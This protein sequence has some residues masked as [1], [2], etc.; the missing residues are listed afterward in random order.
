MSAS[1][2]PVSLVVAIA[3]TCALLMIV[4][5]FGAWITLS[6]PVGT[7][8]ASGTTSG[9]NGIWTAI[10]GVLA[11]GLLGARV[12]GVTW[13][14]AKLPLEWGVLACFVVAG[15]LGFATWTDLT[16]VANARGWSDARTVGRL[17]GVN[18][19][20]APG[21]GLLVVILSAVVGVICSLLLLRGSLAT[22][23]L[24]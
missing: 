2:S 18:L 8:S 12:L 14:D 4:G 6:S 3:G 17:I 13:R 16:S 22:A 5:S 7:F 23:V 15:I 24:D 20:L 9:V 19:D 10:L 11:L 1:R 21:W